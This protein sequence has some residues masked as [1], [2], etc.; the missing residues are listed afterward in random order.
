MPEITLEQK[1]QYNLSSA[2]YRGW[3]PS[4]FGLDTNDY[5]Q[6]LV[7]RIE[8]FQEEYDLEPD[9]MIGP[10]T[11]RRLVTYVTRN[12]TDEPLDVPARA[13]NF[14]SYK[15]RDFPLYW[16]KFL[17]FDDEN[18]LSCRQ[19]KVRGRKPSYFV[20]HW[21]VCKSSISCHRVLAKRKLGVH[22]LLSS[23]GTIYQLADL[24][25]VCYHASGHNSNSVGVEINTA[26][27]LR[28]A[29]YYKE[30]YGQRPIWSGVTVHGKT[31]KPFLGFYD[32]QIQALAA[33][34]AAVSYATGIPLQVPTTKGAVDRLCSSGDFNGFCAHYHLTRRKIDP[35]GL[36]FDRLQEMAILLKLQCYNVGD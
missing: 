16:S 3:C 6:Q 24:E 14:I 11:W 4:W 17:R 28:Y 15:G 34:W 7:E 5:S 13:S 33:L 12:Q 18:G 35:A 29:E 25:S 8:E 21:D 23:D 9:G 32:I 26:Y 31:L 36:D 27:S 10:S 1:I 2:R 22:F 19:R 30:K 20:N